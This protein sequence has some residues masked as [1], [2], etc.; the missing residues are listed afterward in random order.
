MVC[1]LF[2][3]DW[4]EGRLRVWRIA[5]ALGG[6][7]ADTQPYPLQD[8]SIYTLVVLGIFLVCSQLPLYGIKASEGSDPFYWARLIMASNR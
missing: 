8:K 3:E 5:G 4:N 2:E 1:K 7:L 6:I